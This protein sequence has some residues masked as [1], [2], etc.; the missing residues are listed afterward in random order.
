MVCS[1]RIRTGP[2]VVRSVNSW[3]G[4]GRWPS[5]TQFGPVYAN[6][7]QVYISTPAGDA[8]PAVRRLTACLVDIEA[9]LKASRLRL[10]PTKTQV[11]LMWLGS[12]QQLAKVNVSEVPLASA[13]INVSETARNLGVIVDSQLTLSAQ[14]VAVCCSGY[15]Q[16]R[17]LRPIVRSSDHLTP[18][19]R[20]SRRLFRVAWTTATRCSTAA[21]CS[22]CGCTFGVRGS[23]LWPHNAGATG[24]ALASG[25]ASGGLQDGHFGLLVTVRYGS[26]LPGRRLSAGLHRRSSSAAFCQLKDMCRQK[27]LQPSSSSETK[28][29]QRCHW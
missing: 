26:A 11:I 4:P 12:P 20:W 29:P 17:Q 23:T 3:A 14:V 6:D 25:S 2:A 18:P 28:Y 19:R 7:T 15:Y 10:N 13:H 8:E 24:A 16:L 22:E 1:A 27:D 5:W 21:V 9:W